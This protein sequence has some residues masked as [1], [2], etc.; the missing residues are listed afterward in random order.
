MVVLLRPGSEEG[1]GDP[2]PRKSS[3]N[4]A[5]Y[6]LGAVPSCSIFVAG[7]V[8]SEVTQLRRLD[9]LGRGGWKYDERARTKGRSVWFEDCVTLS[10]FV[11]QEC[12]RCEEVEALLP[13][14]HMLWLENKCA[15]AHMCL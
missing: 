2:P 6:E 4:V 10:C 14:M 11:S 9:E 15:R 12:Q 13:K 8:V 7:E 5:L 3:P 1:S